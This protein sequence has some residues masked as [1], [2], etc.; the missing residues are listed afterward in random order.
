VGGHK[1]GGGGRGLVGDVAV[2]VDTTARQ[3]MSLQA[4]EGN[5]PP[6]ERLLS[7]SVTEARYDRHDLSLHVT[8]DLLNQALR[9]GFANIT[10]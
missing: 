1:G 7:A 4:Q 2:S 3:I 8:I 5:M 10:A 9:R 6:S